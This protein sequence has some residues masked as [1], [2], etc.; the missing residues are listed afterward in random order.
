MIRPLLRTI[1]TL[2]GNVKLA[3]TLQDYNTISKNVFETNIRGAH[4]YPL[5]SQLFQKSVEANLLSSSWDY[6][7][8]R[9]YN[10]YSDTFFDPCFTINRQEMPLLDK[11]ENIKPRNIDF[12]YGVK[13]ISYSKSG[14]QYACFAPIYIDNVN[15]IP[16]YFKLTCKI[17]NHNKTSHIEKTI[18]VNIGKNGSDDRNYIYKYLKTYLSKIDNNVIFMDNDKLS[19]VYYGIDLINGGFTKVEDATVS[20]LFNSKLPIQLFD[21]TISEGF[22][23]NNVAMRQVIPMCF[24]FNVDTLLNASEKSRYTL[25]SIEFSGAYYNSNDAKIDWYDF[26]VDYDNFTQDIF[27]LDT[28][29]GE[30][31][32][33]NGN[34]QNI[35]DVVFPSMND[36]WISNYLFANKLSKTFNR[37]RLK[38]SS[39]EDPYI[40][41]MSYAFSK[42]Q[43]NNY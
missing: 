9:F 28:N 20:T 14:C 33:E 23:R 38:Y 13:R 1:P 2:S 36:R 24:Y 11:S 43:N 10:A 15:D 25:G 4:I 39:D 19:V 5:S 37:W 27:V 6:D 35:M 42:N 12:E 26:S 21:Y 22:K 29:N 34:V 18:I 32:L 40:T 17:Y 16:S 30:M 7:I 41:N 3:C 31:K 8:K